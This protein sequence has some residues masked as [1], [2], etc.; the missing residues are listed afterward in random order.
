MALRRDAPDAVLVGEFASREP[1]AGIRFAAQ[2]IGAIGDRVTLALTVQGVR[3]ARRT[4]SLVRLYRRL[5]FE[6]AARY[7]VGT[8]EL[9]LMV[10]R[11]S[12][13]TGPLRP[14]LSES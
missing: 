14:V 10:R 11:A 9:V 2:I 12:I 6:V 5:Q 8:D 1:G 4:R 7:S 13:P 3:D